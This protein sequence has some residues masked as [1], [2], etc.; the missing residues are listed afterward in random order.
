M[1][2]EAGCPVCGEVSSSKFMGPPG[3]HAQNYLAGL[4]HQDDVIYG[5][6][7]VLTFR[8]GTV[9]FSVFIFQV[10]D[11]IEYITAQPRGGPDDS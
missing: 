8:N 3:D 5:C 1:I 2:V 7:H 6:D 4:C 10:D 11:E 9:F